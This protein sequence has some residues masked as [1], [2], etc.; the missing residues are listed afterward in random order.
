MGATFSHTGIVLKSTKLGETDVILT[1]LSE[2]GVLVQGVLKG[3]RNPRSKT[4]GKGELFSV[5]N[6]LFA[7]GK[8]LDIITESSIVESAKNLTCSYEASLAASVVSEVALKTSALGNP[9]PRFFQLTAAALSYLNACASEDFETIYTLVAAYIIKALALQGYRPVLE[10]CSVCFEQPDCFVGWSH[11]AGGA[12][13]AD[14]YD[15][16]FHTAINP[17]LVGWLNHLLMGTFSDLA[18]HPCEKPVLSD[19]THLLRDFFEYNMSTPLK[20]LSIFWSLTS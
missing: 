11:S 5:Q 7:Q 8:S 18:A 9:S 17:E 15:H 14:C 1:L 10:A 20:S 16:A 6:V 12:V 2:E 19:T 4:V 13:C 3:A